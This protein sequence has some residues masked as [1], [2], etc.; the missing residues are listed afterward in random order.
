[1]KDEKTVALI[2]K[3]ISRIKEKY[4]IF[5]TYDYNEEDDLYEIWHNRENLEYHDE[6]FDTYVSK[7]LDK[8]LFSEGYPNVYFTYDYYKS[9]ELFASEPQ[10]NLQM[11]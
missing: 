8:Y 5:I 11:D 7:I 6:E 4:N 10:Q 9:Q 3:V 1:M 2:K